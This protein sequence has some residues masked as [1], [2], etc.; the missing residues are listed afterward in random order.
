MKLIGWLEGKL[1]QR[2]EVKTKTNKKEPIYFSGAKGKLGTDL[3]EE[4][5]QWNRR[6][7]KVCTDITAHHKVKVYR[8][9]S[10]C[11]LI[12]I[13]QRHQNLDFDQNVIKE[14]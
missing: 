4:N 9:D 10:K 7:R 14:I 12:S 13:T 3:E 5:D 1:E 6:D 11:I 8:E 2:E